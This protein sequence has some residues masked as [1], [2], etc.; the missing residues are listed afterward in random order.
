MPGTEQDQAREL[1]Q[2]ALE[3]LRYSQKTN[4]VFN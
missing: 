1:Q 4:G 3:S 2:A